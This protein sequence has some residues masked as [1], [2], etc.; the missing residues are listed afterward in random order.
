MN[1][2]LPVVYLS[3]LLLLLFGLTIFVLRQIIKSR[4]IESTASKLQKKIKDGG[5]VAQDY[6]QLGSIFLD[7]KLL[8]KEGSKG[9]LGSHRG[10]RG[11]LVPLF[12]KVYT[13]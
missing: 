9:N 6:Y 10:L 11:N 1:D 8:E 4:R 12:L 5:G 7:K 3:G 13:I 2:N